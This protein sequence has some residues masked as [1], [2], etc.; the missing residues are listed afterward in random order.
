[1]TDI[2]SSLSIGG[3]TRHLVAL[4]EE[5]LGIVTEENSNSLQ[6][7]NKNTANRENTIQLSKGYI[8]TILAL[9]D[10][11]VVCASPKENLSVWR[12]EGNNLTREQTIQSSSGVLSLLTLPNQQIAS[13]DQEAQLKI[14]NTQNWQCLSTQQI[15]RIEP[16]R[17][18]IWALALSSDQQQ[19]AIGAGQNIHLV[20]LSNSSITGT[21]PS[22]KRH[23]ENVT[24]LAFFNDYV[25]SASLKGLE[26]KIW[27]SAEKKL[28]C[29]LRNVGPL[30]QKISEEEIAITDS[31]A[32]SSNMKIAIWNFDE[33]RRSN[34]SH[35]LQPKKEL[36]AN[37][38]IS[39]LAL[40][41]S[42]A[43][44]AGDSGG[45]VT[46]WSINP[47][48]VTAYTPIEPE[49]DIFSAC[50]PS[51]AQSSIK[52][53]Q[54]EVQRSS[55][56]GFQTSSVNII[57]GGLTQEQQEQLAPSSSSSSSVIS[58]VSSTQAVN[59]PKTAEATVDAAPNLS[60]TVEITIINFQDIQKGNPIG[61]G[62]FGIVYQGTWSNMAVAIKQFPA[63][64]DA[65]VVTEFMKEA[66]LHFQLRHENVV[67]MMGI[68]LTPE[69]GIVMEYCNKGSLRMV[70]NQNRLTQQ[71]K[72]N[73]ALGV[74]K[75][76]AYLHSQRIIHG[77][78]K[79]DNIVLNEQMIPKIT[80]FG[81]SKVKQ[82]I[83]MTTQQQA[84]AGTLPWMAP[85]LFKRGARC[86][87]ESDIYSL[88]MVL[89]EI[90]TQAV[91]FAS[92]EKTFAIPALVQQGVR[93]PIPEETPPAYKEVIETNWQDD[94]QH[95]ISAQ[96]TVDKLIP[97]VASIGMFS[98]QTTPMPPRYAGNLS[99]CSYNPG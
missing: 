64:L 56:R 66:K 38:S 68:F 25:I 33:L 92:V 6:I 21:F 5:Y 45:S 23:R 99:S 61:K 84:A 20:T 27:N 11:R 53:P 80:D 24:S 32:L 48:K 87:S 52:L 83:R 12:M 59:T 58:S 54:T 55:N 35:G 98:Q 40:L 69:Y 26:V 17:H 46:V 79:S 41:P 71:E 14:W 74:A 78:L 91:P 37:K 89:W 96:A 10:G 22:D 65:T 28:S 70:L 13:G 42:G 1:M 75:G 8:S 67:S 9:G 90:L 29:D 88:A 93:E 43:L 51:S 72:L 3:K 76:L 73:I 36:P 16:F 97:L 95:R 62:S 81:L 15:I 94:P 85:E 44:I 31:Y 82:S 7:W 86:N 47:T 30:F 18:P 2:L 77:D 34:S 39:A 57:E 60:A 4:T 19:L 49:V 50:A 63:A